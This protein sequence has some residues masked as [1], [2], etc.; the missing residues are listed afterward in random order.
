EFEHLID[1]IDRIAARRPLAG[2]WEDRL[3]GEPPLPL[4][5]RSRPVEQM[6]VVVLELPVRV[7]QPVLLEPRGSMLLVEARQMLDPKRG[8]DPVRWEDRLRDGDEMKS[9]VRKGLA[10][11]V[12]KKPIHPIVRSIEVPVVAD[13]AV[14]EESIGEPANG[15]RL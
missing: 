3:A 13:H 10:L 2:R 6:V 8:L 1:R 12:C 4:S 7:D 15:I 5:H 9:P 14:D 11:L